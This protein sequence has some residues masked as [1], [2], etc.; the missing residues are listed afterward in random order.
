M[1]A[2]R[3]RNKSVIETRSKNIQL[4]RHISQRRVDSTKKLSN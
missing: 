1:L 4:I 3:A 2:L